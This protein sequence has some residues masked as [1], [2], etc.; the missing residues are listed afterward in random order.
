[1]RRIHLNIFAVEKQYYTFLCV[2]VRAC[3]GVG[4]RAQACA[5]ARVA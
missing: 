5:F 3:V 4:S 1:M 2:R